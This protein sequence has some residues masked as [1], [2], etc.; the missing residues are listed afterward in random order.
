[1]IRISAVHARE[2]GHEPLVILV[3]GGIIRLIPVILLVV[4][5]NLLFKSGHRG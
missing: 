1:M 4:T 3:F 5:A 2:D